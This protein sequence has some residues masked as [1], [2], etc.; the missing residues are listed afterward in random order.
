MRIFNPADAGDD[1]ALMYPPS[2][3]LLSVGHRHK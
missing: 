3:P 2:M 1:D